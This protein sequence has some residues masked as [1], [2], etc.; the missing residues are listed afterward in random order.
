MRLGAYKFLRVLRKLLRK[1]VDGGRG[2]EVQALKYGVERMKKETER[3]LQFHF[4]DYRENIKFGYVFKM[5]EAAS[6][7]ISEGLLERFETYENDLDEMVAL[8]DAS[9][10]DKARQEASFREVAARADHLYQHGLDLR[11]QLITS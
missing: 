9:Q 11:Q 3:S 10:S 5:V 8:I 6:N 2:E 7:Q 1:S 4:K